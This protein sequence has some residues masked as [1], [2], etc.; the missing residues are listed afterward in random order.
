MWWF[1]H[2]K[3]IARKRDAFG[4]IADG[5]F[6]PRV[7]P[8]HMGDDRDDKYRAQNRYLPKVAKRA[9]A[10]LRLARKVTRR[11]VLAGEV[12]SWGEQV[13]VVAEER[14]DEVEYFYAETYRERRE[15]AA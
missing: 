12:S 6:R 13:N 14:C 3:T 4:L 5:E 2:P 10:R 9:H 7:S 11:D 15:F 1:R 8:R